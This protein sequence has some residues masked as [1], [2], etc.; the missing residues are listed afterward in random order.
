MQ[1]CTLLS[2]KTGGCPETCTYCAQS[3]SWSKDVGL[4][5]EKLMGMEE[6]LEVRCSRLP[7]SAFRANPQ[8]H[9]DVMAH[10]TSVQ[11]LHETDSIIQKNSDT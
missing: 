11:A 9:F 1:R 10:S 2:I 6:V 5:A 3:T 8:L 7:T 4:K